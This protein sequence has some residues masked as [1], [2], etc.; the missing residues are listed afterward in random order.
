MTSVWKIINY[1]DFR[2]S[3][4]SFHRTLINTAE[5][6]KWKSAD[7]IN[8]RRCQ[9]PWFDR[10]NLYINVPCQKQ[11]LTARTCQCIPYSLNVMYVVFHLFGNCHILQ[12]AKCASHFVVK[13]R[14][15]ISIMCL[16]GHVKVI[17]RKHFGDYMPK[18]KL[19]RHV[20]DLPACSDI[21]QTPLVGC[22]I[23]HED[24]TDVRNSFPDNAANNGL[25]QKVSARIRGYSCIL[26]KLRHL[27][28]VVQPV[29]QPILAR[30]QEAWPT[31]PIQDVIS[32]ATARFLRWLGKAFRKGMNRTR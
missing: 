20:C 17:S 3:F 22:D 11:K 31:I 30:D 9:A 28:H 13:M 24:T 1:N 7:E 8:S 32:L 18:T 14:N 10:G 4:I 5:V 15:K 23:S 29:L 21:N 2:K 27:L 12:I 16:L 26:T 6:R 25:H 19:V